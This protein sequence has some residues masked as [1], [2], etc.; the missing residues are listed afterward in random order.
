MAIPM[1]LAGILIAVCIVLAC[2]GELWDMRQE[3][4]QL[5]KD[6]LEQW[7]RWIAEYETRQQQ[8]RVS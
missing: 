1:F 4:K 7:D 6:E 5:E 2:L 3:Q 8:R